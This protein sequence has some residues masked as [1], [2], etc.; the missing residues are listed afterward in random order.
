MELEKVA[1]SSFVLIDAA[2]PATRVLGLIEQL[3]PLRLIVRRNGP[4]ESYYLVR[5][6]IA[7]RKLER[8][9]P[10]TPIEQALDWTGLASVPLL[11][12][13]DDESAYAGPCIVHDGGRIIGYRESGPP[14]VFEAA[15]VRDLA[16]ADAATAGGAGQS[17]LAEFPEKVQLDATASLLVSLVREFVPG[18]SLA[19]NLPRGSEI[20]LVIQARR[21]FVLDGPAEGKLEVSGEDEGLPLQFKLRATSTGPGQIRVLAFHTGRPLGMITLAPVV[22]E[23]ECAVT[24]GLQARQGSLAPATVRIPDLSLLILESKDQG[25]TVLSLRLTSADPSLGYNLKPFGPVRLRSEPYGYFQNFFGDIEKLPIQSSQDKAK[26]EQRLAAKG[27]N[28]FEQLVPEELRNI[29][30]KLRARITSVQVQSEEPWIPW[31]LCKLVGKSGE[32]GEIEEGP[33][34]CEAFQL[35]RWIPGVGQVP[36]VRMKNIALVVPD[37]SRLPFA[38]SERDFVLSLKAEGRNVEPIPASFLDVQAALASGMY[39]CW[40]FSGHGS[41]R[42]EPQPERSAMILQGGDRLTPEDLSGRVANLGR[43]HPLVFLNACQIGQSGMGLTG[44]GGWASRF[45]KAGAGGF[46]GAYWSIYDQP[47]L[48]FAKAFYGRLLAGD[49]LG[50]AAREA[51]LAIRK[52]G[53]PTWLAYTVFADP[54]AGVV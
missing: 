50:K 41:F 32:D 38:A 36:Q 52:T 2:W 40:H 42:N 26:V 21:G 53:D 19:I 35:T 6:G 24:S 33:F 44:M 45:L 8:S 23:S 47:A 14:P 51:R 12:G 43:A 22:V 20:D 10:S 48:D 27:T 29:L 30:W 49:P 11:E 7:R 37:D 17:L 34:F 54:M 28:L 13:A 39:D 16:A 46:L 15:E 4:P 1:S 31:E 25:V 5:P 9:E 18:A 3:V